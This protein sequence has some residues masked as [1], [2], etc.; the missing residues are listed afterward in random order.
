MTHYRIRVFASL[1][2]RLRQRWYVQCPNALDVGVLKLFHN[3][4]QL[5]LIVFNYDRHLQQGQW[6]N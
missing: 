2:L 6:I 5:A 3:A 4:I 1:A